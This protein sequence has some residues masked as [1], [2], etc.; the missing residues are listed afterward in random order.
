MN[1]FDQFGKDANNIQQEFLG[2]NYDYAKN[3]LSPT[4]I[5]MLQFS[6]EN[7]NLISNN[8]LPEL[9]ADFAGLISY[10]ELL[11]SGTT[12][13]SKT[14]KPLGNR[15]FLPTAG[16]C[17]DENNI[18]QTRYVYVNNIPTGSIP[19]ISSIAGKDF[20]EFR[21]LIPGIFT[22]LEVLNPLALFGGMMTSADASCNEVELS[23]VNKN[24][25]E[26]F[27]K[28]N[29]LNQD[30]QNISPC[31]FKGKVN[32]LTKESCVDSE[33]FTNIN[34]NISNKNSLNKDNVNNDNLNNIF[35]EDN[36]IKIYFIVLTLLYFY[37]FIKLF[38]KK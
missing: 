28:H 38:F 23:V 20:T 2:P 36:L 3:I 33:A 11:V 22:D 26:I 32:T 31:V 6:G 29:I 30:I 27:E 37:I 5:N 34:N 10:V 21:G 24:N 7:F 25:T 8:G 19:I 14:G 18:E 35:N 9:A 16:K 15:Y 13:A 4:E 12:I 17:K 1:F